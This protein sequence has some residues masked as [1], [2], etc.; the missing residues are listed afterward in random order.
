MPKYLISLL[1]QIVLLALIISKTQSADQTDEKNA[2]AAITASPYSKTVRPTTDTSIEIYTNFIQ[3]VSVEEKTQ[4]IT[5]ISYL[6]LSWEDSRLA[7]T[8]ATY[9]G[10][11]EVF[12]PIK[13]IWTPDIAIINQVFFLFKFLI[14]INLS[15]NYKN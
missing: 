13:N 8:K 9:N 5:T 6:T 10:L 12:I 11:E 15:N 2:I 4:T 1:L 14:S 7:W 3:L